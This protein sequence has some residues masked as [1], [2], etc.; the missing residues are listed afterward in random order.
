[1]S[2]AFFIFVA[3]VT[4]ARLGYTFSATAKCDNPITF[5]GVFSTEYSTPRITA[6]L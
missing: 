3:L 2:S 4:Y 1:M 5:S 6:L